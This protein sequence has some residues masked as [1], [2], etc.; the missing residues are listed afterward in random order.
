MI[1]GLPPFY[2]TDRKTLFNNIQHEELKFTKYHD[3]VVQD[4][5]SQLLMKDPS[6]R[7]ASAAEIM[8][9]DFF[10]GID[11]QKMEQR[12]LRTPYTPEVLGPLDLRHF[13]QEQTSK[14]IASSPN[15]LETFGKQA[16]GGSKT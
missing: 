11:W 16:Q 14:P 8:A 9:H 1:S 6:E 5:L 7:L 4:L 15:S 13:E 12:K 2:S 10:A 3:A